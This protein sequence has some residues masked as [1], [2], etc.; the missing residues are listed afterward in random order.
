MS[1]KF[2]HYDSIDGTTDTLLCVQFG[3]FYARLVCL[4]K[5]DADDVDDDDE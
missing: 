5:A 3:D 1:N 2:R 4:F